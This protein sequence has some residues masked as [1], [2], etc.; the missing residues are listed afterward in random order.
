VEIE[1]CVV[2]RFVFLFEDYCADVAAV[3]SWNGKIDALNKSSVNKLLA[4]ADGV[5][6]VSVFVRGDD[7]LPSLF[8]GFPQLF[9]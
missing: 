8:K 9:H 2:G 7:S 6:I 5:D 1:E 4:R 3:V